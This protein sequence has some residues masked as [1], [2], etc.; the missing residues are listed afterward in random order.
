MIEVKSFFLALV[1][2]HGQDRYRPQQFQVYRRQVFQ[3][4]PPR[5]RPTWVTLQCLLICST[6]IWTLV[7][8]DLARP[9]HNILLLTTC[10]NDTLFHQ[11]I[12]ESCWANEATNFVLRYNLI[13]TC[14]K[15][16]NLIDNLAHQQWDMWPKT[17]IWLESQWIRMSPPHY[18]L[19]REMLLCICAASRRI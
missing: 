6:K 10:T 1:V 3:Y 8:L 13:V 9:N 18:L 17:F 11:D 14:T 19:Q 4:H 7:L 12:F 2:Y 16:A 5:L 15:C